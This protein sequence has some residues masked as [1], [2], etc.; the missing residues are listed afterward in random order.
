GLF[1]RPFMLSAATYLTAASL[2]GAALALHLATGWLGES[3]EPVFLAHVAFAAGG[4][5][6]M[7]VFGAAYHLLPFFGLTAKK[8]T[9]RYIGLVRYSLH[10]S[11]WLFVARAVTG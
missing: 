11:V 3:W 2:A 7:L 9:P 1:V 10:G 4:W 6:P 8:R 5:F